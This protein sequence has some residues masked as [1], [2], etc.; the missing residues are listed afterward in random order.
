MSLLNISENN[1]LSVEL[2]GMAAIQWQQT[3]QLRRRNPR[4]DQYMSDVQKW[5][6][7]QNLGLIASQPSG[8]G[9]RTVQF[10]YEG[11]AKMMFFVEANRLVIVW[12]FEF[13]R[14]RD[15]DQRI[16]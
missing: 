6:R 16:H 14:D 3:A 9:D 13:L 4:I 8:S 2:S 1:D 7:R 11:I 12:L 15:E 5:A 10:A